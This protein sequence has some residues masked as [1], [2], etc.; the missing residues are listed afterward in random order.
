[1]EGTFELPEAQRDRFMLKLTVD[2]PDRDD[3]RQILDRFAAQPELGA[4]DVEQV[5]TA[6]DMQ[7]ARDVVTDV[8]VADSIQEYVLD[9]V[10]AT[11]VHPDVEHGGSVRASL[12]LLSTSKARAAI[13]DRAYVIPDDVKAMAR[14]VLVHRLVLTTEAELSDVRPTSVVEDVLGSVTPPGGDPEAEL[15]TA[16]AKAQ[17]AA[18]YPDDQPDD[19]TDKQAADGGRS[20]PNGPDI[21]SKE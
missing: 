8:Y 18:K 11:R 6:A 21:D 13:H 1:M 20:D 5:V 9:L 15:D 10:G 14:P 4:A 19:G 16:E 12:A 2:V 7:H 3:E 17:Y